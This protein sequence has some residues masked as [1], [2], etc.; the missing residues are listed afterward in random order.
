M[1]DQ[2]N[3]YITFDEFILMPYMGLT[4]FLEMI[5]EDEIYSYDINTNIELYLKPRKSGEMFFIVRLYFE[6]DNKS[7]KYVLLSIQDN[8]EIPSWNDWS[9]EREL[10]RKK[11]NDNWL[12]QE[13]AMVPLKFEWGSLRSVF[14]EKDG[15]SYVWVDFSQGE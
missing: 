7:L 2:I 3:G 11:R 1:I 13:F 12:Q 6:Q 5:G 8:D 9:K 10:E 14:N 4:K 15:S